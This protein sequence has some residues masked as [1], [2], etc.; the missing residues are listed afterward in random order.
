MG[1]IY[2]IT[3]IRGGFIFGGPYRRNGADSE[4]GS[5][6]MVREAKFKVAGHDFLPAL[7]KL[8]LQLVKIG[9][10]HVL[11]NLVHNTDSTNEHHIEL[12]CLF[13]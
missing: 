10:I 6:G 9:R 2:W 7:S 8:C 1:A 5:R 12:I 11:Y 3:F 4:L 13:S